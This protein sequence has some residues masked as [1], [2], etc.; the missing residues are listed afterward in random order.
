MIA[1][2]CPG[3][4]ALLMLAAC[5][6][7]AQEGQDGQG[8][9]TAAGQPA[10]DAATASDPVGEFRTYTI[11]QFMDTEQVRGATFSAD[12][13]RV[14]YSSNRSGVFNVYV[15]RVIGGKPE[16]LTY[17]SESPRYVESFFPRDDRLLFSGDQ[18]GNELDHVYLRRGT[19]KIV[20]LTPGENLKADFIGFSADG[21]KFW[22]STNER[23]PSVFDLYEYDTT[24]LQRERIFEN[25]V[26]AFLGPVSP[27]GRYVALR[28]V[29]LRS[30]TDILLWD[31]ETGEI[32]TLVADEDEVANTPE[33]FSV[34]ARALY[35][36]TDRGSEFAWLVRRDLET[37]DETVVLQP[38]WDVM[39]AGRS[40]GGRYLV[41][42]V[43]EDARTTLTVL[44]AETHAEYALP[45]LPDGNIT[46][47]TFSAD[48]NRMAFYVS[49]SR[50]PSDLYYTSLLPGA[51][52]PKA[53]TSSLNPEIAREHLVEGEVIR[54]ESYD[55]LEIPGILYRPHGAS[56]ESP[57][58]ALVSVHGGPGGQARIGYSPLKQYLVNRGYA[59]FDINNRGSSG[60][61][62]TFFAAD[63]RCHGECDL[64][65]V[66]ASKE[67]LAGLDW[68]DGDRI[69]IIGGSYGGYMVAAALAFE[70]EVFDAGVDIFG[71]TN[72]LR[73]LESIPAW[74]GPQRDALFAELGDPAEDAER[75]RRIS[76]LFHAD[77]ITKP[78]IVLQGAN[79]PRVLQV[80]S[81]EIVQALR[82]NGVPVEYVLFDDEGHGFRN[83]DNEIEGYR[84]IRQFL[85]THLAQSHRAQSSPDN[86]D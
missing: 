72:W 24:T 69:G 49:G 55:G 11:E 29:H 64:G 5:G 14:A 58:P 13:K 4:L 26:D 38:D 33:T 52:P 16:Q 68:I 67:M 62:K 82:D 84:A 44:D 59:I 25:T 81:D 74:W 71:V 86:G 66:V 30:N 1:R 63:D 7:P 60:Y 37:G 20:D 83:R 28:K 77:D 56:A 73:T 48:D 40:R 85:D 27:D 79:D 2:I 53:L 3:L 42:G 47:A 18:G 76:P 78:M 6:P 46:S 51:P 50:R 19:G 80:E 43:N 15:Q 35:Y 31:R 17:S 45:T 34:D 75:L 23:D 70:P 54:F 36:T 41:A 22:I 9:P 57:A 32:E 12:G 21:G 8:G 10:G 61:G 39:Y 65:D